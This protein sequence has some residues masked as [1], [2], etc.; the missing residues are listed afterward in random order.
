MT[1]NGYQFGTKHCP[2][3][4]EL[5]AMKEAIVKEVR[6][7]EQGGVY[8]LEVGGIKVGKR[9]LDAERYTFT[10]SNGSISI[11]RKWGNKTIIPAENIT[12]Y[13]NNIELEQ[14]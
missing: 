10:R 12:D 11:E 7:L 4:E 9:V 6:G 1:Y 8:L 3:L 14:N 5:N 2:S 13:I